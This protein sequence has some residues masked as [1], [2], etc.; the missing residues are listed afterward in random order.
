MEKGELIIEGKTK[1]IFSVP[2]KPDMAIVEYKNAITAFDDPSFTKE[3]AT[4][5]VH[6][7]TITCRVFELLKNAG[8]PVAYE[9]QISE[10][11]FLA[12]KCDMIP[13][14]V[15]ARRYAV[16]SYLKRHPEFEK[17]DGQETHRFDELKI[18]FFL[19]TSRGKLVKDGKTL[20]EGLDP[21]AGEEDPFIENP[22]EGTWHLK[23]PK[24]QSGEAGSDLEKEIV[25]RDVL[26]NPEHVPDI[27]ATT[28]SV[29][30]ALE[31]FWASHDF[32]LI[33]FKLEFGIAPDGVL[34]VADVIDNDSWRLRD[35]NWNDVSKQSFRD[36]EGLDVIEDK[37]ALVASV[38]EGT[39]RA[40]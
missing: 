22:R 19:K 17:P 20:V 28:K 21:K 26:P 24:K 4:K 40:C 12:P 27:Q 1:K 30:E 34:M 14:E 7:N 8:L 5:A 25:A 23:H 2:G 9:K 3:F 11:E 33:D 15:V 6:S 37:Y 16:G 35:K 31:N 10:T 36:G 18:E 38:L 39:I 13:L 32:K 29:F